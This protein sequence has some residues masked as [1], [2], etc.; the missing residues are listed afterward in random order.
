[1]PAQRIGEASHPGPL[2]AS[3]D[4]D[5]VPFTLGT[6]NVAGLGNKVP[7]LM[8]LPQG[9]WGLCE[10]HLTSYGIGAVKTQ[11][12]CL[13]KRECRMLRLCHGAP[14]PPRVEDSGS[15]KW[16]GV[17]TMSDYP[18]RE[19]QVP[20]RGEEFNCGRIVLT[21]SFVNGTPISGA[22]IYGAARSPTF[23]DPYKITFDLMQTATEELVDGM[24]GP[25]YL[26]GDFNISAFQMPQE[27][28]WHSQGW[29][30]L[31]IHANE[32]W[33]YPIR[34]TCKGV[35][36]R[37]FVWVSPELL[38]MLKDVHVL[39]GLFPDHSAVY[40]SFVCPSRPSLIHYWH[41]PHVIPWQ[42]V[43]V[44]SWQQSIHT[45]RAPFDWR[46]DLTQG[47]AAWSHGVE[48]SLDGFVATDNR[49]LPVGC[50][51]RG[52]RKPIRKGLAQVHVMRPSRP[53]EI[54]LTSSICNGGTNNCAVCSHC[55]IVCAVGPP[56]VAPLLTKRFAGRP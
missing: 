15:G 22:T 19:L 10:T 5:F 45:N 38:G 44:P 36:V 25:R 20:W 14:A 53:G 32:Q 43:D 50:R 41:F 42:E 54:A 7:S 18:L 39:P 56:A 28:Y 17:L 11:A 48:K 30:E 46:T 1:M 51:G 33:C 35:T 9:I 23:L 13:A 24:T 4:T 8:D 26:M 12:K 27:A 16:T 49:R 21:T 6:A 47:F 40:G 55:F 37:D 34:P 3:C 2:D 52:R 29:R 31:Q